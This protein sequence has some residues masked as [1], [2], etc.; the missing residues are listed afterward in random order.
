MTRLQFILVGLFAFVDYRINL[1]IGVFFCP[2]VNLMLLK[3]ED[4]F[5]SDEFTDEKTKSLTNH[6]VLL[7]QIVISTIVVVLDY[8]V[9]V[10]LNYLIMDKVKGIM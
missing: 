5:K 9:Q 10:Q 2:I 6:S 4:H 7:I 1:V 8:L 3:R